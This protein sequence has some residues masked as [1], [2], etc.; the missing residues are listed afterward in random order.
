MLGFALIWYLWWRRPA[1][2]ADAME[3]P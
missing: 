1:V 2:R 3:R